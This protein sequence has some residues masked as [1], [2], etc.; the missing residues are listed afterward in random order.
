MN[1]LIESYLRIVNVLIDTTNCSIEEAIINPAIPEEYREQIKKEYYKDNYITIRD[2]SVVTDPNRESKQWLP[3]I[4]RNSWYYWPRLRNYLIDSKGWS[5]ETVRSIDDATD[6]ILGAMDNPSSNEE[7]DT[8]GLVV[9]YVQS[10]KTANYTA[11]ISKAVDTGYKIIIVLAGMQNSLRYQTQTRLDKELVGISN[12]RQVGVKRPSPEKEWQTFTKADLHNGDFNPGNSSAGLSGNNPVL[13]VVKK[14]GT[15]L[16]RLLS[17]LEQSHEDTRRTVP[18][19]I[20]DDEADQ[21][22]INTGGNKPIDIDPDYEDNED[23]P[24]TINDLI[25]KLLNMFTKKAYIAYTATPFANVLIDHEAVDV[26]AGHDLYP[27]SFIVAL[28]KPNNYLGATEI[29]GSSDNPDDRLNVIVHVP[30]NEI[31]DLVPQHRNEVESFQPNI[32]ESLKEAI[33]DFILA[34]AARHQRESANVP[35]SMLIHTSY[36]TLIQERLTTLIVKYFSELRDDWRYFREQG[37]R[38]KFEKIWNEKFRPLTR[39]INVNEDK[40]FYEIESHI[41]TFFEK[42]D[43]IQLHSESEDQINYETD[44]NQCVIVIGGNRLSR[45]LTIEGLLVSYFVRSSATYDTLMQM[46][47]WFGY[48]RDYADL[49]RIYTTA[50]LDKWFRDLA[51]VEEELH[52]EIARYQREKL[53]P[54]EV[55]IKI[56]QHSSMLVTSPLKM[57]AS[58]ILNISYENQLLQTITFPLNNKIWLDSNLQ[59]T[60]GF[61]KSLGVP[62]L[63]SSKNKPVWKLNEPSLIL[64]F[65]AEY[66]TDPFATRVRCEKL[67]EYIIKQNNYQELN[68]WTVSIIGRSKHNEE[69]GKIDFGITGRD[70]INLIER[71]K[72]KETNSLKAIVSQDDQEIGLNDSQL[73][74]AM[75]MSENDNNLSYVE[76]LRHVRDSDE[77]L[78]LIYPISKYSGYKL[79][80]NNNEDSNNREPLFEDFDQGQHIIGMALVFPKSNTAATV[81]YVV[82]SVGALSNEN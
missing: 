31:K 35:T 26:N 46:G 22:S 63:N 14:N 74:L 69:L 5:N 55:G 51:T 75:E 48:R 49:T 54:L 7:F 67:R 77:G 59:I 25:R 30:K 70:G 23:S 57:K 71:T 20:I 9:G 56:R 61:I 17:W 13:L 72:I 24:S 41:S 62:L 6:K 79:R 76:A 60:K 73:A 42:V 3:Y 38:S 82:G 12:G 16:R 40:S 2:P 43:I 33:I 50:I 37:L 19:L 80:Y 1:S 32:P 68:K 28:P 66:K 81:Q 47:R 18:C 44:P 4:D 36:R 34:G 29:F 53:T 58:Q 8:K 52:R 10:G 45:G 27:K 78:L 21:A 39:S 64:D 11:L 65:L 15:V